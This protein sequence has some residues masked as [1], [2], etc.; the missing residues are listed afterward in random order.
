MGTEANLR[1]GFSL[2]DWEVLPDRSLIRDGS[3]EVRVEP[4]PMNVLVALAENQGEVLTKDDLVDRVWGGRAIA[5]GPILRAISQVRRALGDDRSEPK[6]IENIPRIGYRLL[7]PVV[8]KEQPVEQPVQAPAPTLPV[9]W[10]LGVVLF[11]AAG[12]LAWF[13]SC[14][15][16]R[17][18]CPAPTP[19]LAVHR[20]ECTSATADHLCLGFSEELVSSLLESG[21]VK[22]V[23]L[24]VPIPA[25]PC[26]Q[27]YDV[28]WKVGGTVQQNN[29]AIKAFAEVISC[30]DGTVKRQINEE[31]PV[32]DLFNLQK[33]VANSISQSLF[34]QDPTPILI[35]SEPQN[36]D[37]YTLYVQGR[38][39]LE[40]RSR[41]AIERSIESFNESIALDPGYGPAYLQL[42][43]AYLLMPEYNADLDINDYY[44]RAETA[45]ARGVEADDAIRDAAATV[46]GFIAH[47][48]RNWLEAS[49]EFERATGSDVVRAQ[50]HNW[51]SRFLATTGQTNE[52]LLQAQQ[53]YTSAPQS[54]TIVSRLAIVHLWRGD[55]A[56][57]GRYFEL[58]R[59]FEPELPLH[60]LAY[61][62]YLIETGDLHGARA[63]AKIGLEHFGFDTNWVDPV[64]DGLADP[65][66]RDDAIRRIELLEADGG[67][68]RYVVLALWAVFG[69]ADRAIRTANGILENIEGQDA[70][71]GLEIL[72]SRQL[73]P[74]VQDHA[75]LPGLLERA[76]LTAY[77]AAIGCAWANGRLNC[78]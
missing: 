47:K 46:T 34:P 11:T 76:G 4:L 22:I 77:W 33:T 20:F 24:Q 43:H 50:A 37:A 30:A 25:P 26:D 65:S 61:S 63:A 18:G 32:N 42:A 56:E 23:K 10:M 75:E 67:L 39:Q 16:F 52:A 14:S 5:D 71:M 69:E 7:V 68:S 74:L 2:G 27:Q 64:F 29:G 53:A 40:Q 70:E 62:M 72:F 9:N 12:A 49:A 15:L 51:Y 35:A 55:L 41:Y 28:D 3:N 44:V 13:F 31:A 17:V 57:A 48:R 1:K 59:S 73:L 78:E 21:R 8:P 45:I 54:A 58:A 6:Y 38:T 19:S 66:R 36:D 60:Y